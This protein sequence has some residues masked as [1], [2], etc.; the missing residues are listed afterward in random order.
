MKKT[1]TMIRTGLV[2]L[3]LSA[4]ASVFGQTTGG[5]ISRPPLAVGPVETTY[6]DPTRADLLDDVV[7]DPFTTAYEELNAVLFFN[8]T[9][10]GS[11][12]T[13]VASRTEDFTGID[14]APE[15][16]AQDFTHYRWSYMGADNGSAAV[17][18]TAF[19]PNLA[20]TTGWLKEYKEANDNKLTVTGLTEGYHY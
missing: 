6:N 20:T 10:P 15:R 19:N 17:D 11:G 8:P 9:N 7:T 5:T 14:P 12:L 13:L 1:S 18:G 3:L 16:S 2:A 4:T